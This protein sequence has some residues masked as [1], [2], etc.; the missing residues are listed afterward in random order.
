MTR[1]LVSTD[2]S[3]ITGPRNADG[4]MRSSEFLRPKVGG[5]LGARS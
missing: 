1:S 4:S 2:A 5:D 3:V